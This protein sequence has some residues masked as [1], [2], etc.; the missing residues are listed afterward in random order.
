LRLTPSRIKE[1][2]YNWRMI[3]KNTRNKPMNTAMSGVVPQP[4]DT[5][6]Y[7]AFR[8]LRISPS[9]VRCDITLVFLK[10]SLQNSIIVIKNNSKSLVQFMENATSIAVTVAVCVICL[11]AYAIYVSF[12]PANKGL[13]DQFEEHED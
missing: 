1:E 8:G 9:Q 2:L 6:P 11:T 7:S 10:E 12:G 5:F 13:V 4:R 3:T